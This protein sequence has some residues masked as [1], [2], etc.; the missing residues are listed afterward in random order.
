MNYGLA[1]S[2]AV[3]DL[4]G[5]PCAVLRSA[6]ERLQSVI[7]N[8]ACVSALQCVVDDLTELLVSLD[9]CVHF[10]S[11]REQSPWLETVEALPERALYWRKPGSP[12]SKARRVVS[13]D[14]LAGVYWGIPH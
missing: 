8:L 7:A 5:L 14:D 10:W 11:V 2:A 3:G 13:F 4:Y 12:V 9:E 1:D 6:T